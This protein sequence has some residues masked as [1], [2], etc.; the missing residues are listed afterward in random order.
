MASRLP[1]FAFTTPVTFSVEWL[2]AVA[3]YLGGLL[4]LLTATVLAVYQPSG[5]IESTRA[6][7][8]KVGAT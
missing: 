4:V 6:L 2:G 3:A 8:G 5:R 7:S 1:K